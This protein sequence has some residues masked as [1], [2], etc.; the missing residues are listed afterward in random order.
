VPPLPLTLST[1]LLAPSV[2][3]I[4]G[5]VF[6]ARKAAVIGKFFPTRLRARVNSRKDR[7]THAG[8]AQGQSSKTKVKGPRT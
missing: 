6:E 5:S 1:R 8:Q 4:P 2:G 3:V 7:S